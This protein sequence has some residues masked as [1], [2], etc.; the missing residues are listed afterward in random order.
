MWLVICQVTDDV[1]MYEVRDDGRN[2]KVTHH[3]GLFLVAPAKDDAMPLGGSESASDESTTWSAL[4][5]LTPLEWKSEICL[6]YTS[7]AAD[8]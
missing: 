6:L 4:V 8:E 1:A 2:I 5:E 3:N 7:D